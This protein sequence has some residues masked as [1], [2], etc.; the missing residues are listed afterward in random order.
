MKQL[1]IDLTEQQE[2]FLK[3]FAEKHYE[4]AP[5]NLYTANAIHFVETKRYN[6]IPYHTEIAAHYD[7]ECLVFTTDDDYDYWTSDETEIIRDTYDND[8]CPV[9]I[10]SFRDLEYTHFTGVDGE[11]RFISDY[12]DYFESYSVTIK[13]IAWRQ[14][15]YEK[16]ALFYIL[17][18]AK[19]YME[20]QKHNLNEPRTFTESAGY[21]NYGDFVHFRDLLMTMGKRLINREEKKEVTPQGNSLQLS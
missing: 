18:E 14:E 10:K 16:V 11:E 12:D 4:G 9:P 2:K 7:S 21:A 6:Y 17:D 19:R 20:Y 15:Y 5:D 13:A 3:I 1:T 8:D